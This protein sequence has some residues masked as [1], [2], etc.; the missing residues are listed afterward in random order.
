MLTS[1]QVWGGYD[2]GGTMQER[3]RNYAGIGLATVGKHDFCSSTVSQQN[4]HVNI[5]I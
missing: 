2:D 4:R 5:E 3:W 1:R